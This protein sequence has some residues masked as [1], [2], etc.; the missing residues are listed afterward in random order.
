MITPVIIRQLINQCP[1][2]YATAQYEA[3]HGRCYDRDDYMHLLHGTI[4]PAVPDYSCENSN[5]QSSTRY[6]Y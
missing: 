5:G 1:Y 3:G 6:V 4:L 2:S